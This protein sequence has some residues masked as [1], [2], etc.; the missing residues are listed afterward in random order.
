MAV[1]VVAVSELFKLIE[2]FDSKPRFDE[3]IV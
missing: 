1:V 3:K 2:I